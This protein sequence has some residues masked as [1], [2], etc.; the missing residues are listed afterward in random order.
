MTK[1]KI[2]T[3]LGNIIL[4]LGIVLYFTSII[5]A[6]MTIKAFMVP[7]FL[8]LASQLPISEL[9]RKKEA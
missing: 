2:A 4:L 1:T 8:L 7:A 9:F 5:N 3:A 6:E